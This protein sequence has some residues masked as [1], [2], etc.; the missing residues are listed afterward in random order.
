MTLRAFFAFR[1]LLAGIAHDQS[2]AGFGGL[3]R[4]KPTL[5][6]M[7]MLPNEKRQLK[8]NRRL[9]SVWK[10][11]CEGHPSDFRG[12]PPKDQVQTG[13]L[14]N[15]KRRMCD[16]VRLTKAMVVTRAGSIPPGLMVR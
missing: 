10:K 2:Q 8:W 3:R 7:A 4:A 15:A 9:Q 6:E 1:T 5:G 13:H 11:T 12:N 14:F 16:E